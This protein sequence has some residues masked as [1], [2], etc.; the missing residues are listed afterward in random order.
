M[1]AV[2]RFHQCSAVITGASSGLG[3]QFARQLA[4]DARC[5]LLAARREGSLEQVRDELLAL[6][7]ALKVILRPCDVSTA[8]GRAALLRAVKDSGMKPNLLINNA[9]VGDYGAFASADEARLRGQIDLN[10]TSLVLLTH[11]LLPLMERSADAPAAV[12][13]VASLAGTLPMPDAAVYA[14]TKAF[15]ISFTEAV[16]VE[17]AGEHVIVSAVCPGPTPTNFGKNARRPDGSDTDRSGQGLLRIPPERVVSAGLEALSHGRACVFPGAGV[18]VAARLF[19]LM[20]R[21]LMRWSIERRH[22]RG[23]A[24]E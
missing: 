2:F 17:L 7:P 3:A 22:A 24:K 23:R 18:S 15:V 14:A 16:R 6:N 10:I 9:G 21:A 19:R 12:L 5:V 4:P 20:P 8:E 11:A 13:N 1:S